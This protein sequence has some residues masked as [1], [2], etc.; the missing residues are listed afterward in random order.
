MS[1]RSPPCKVFVKWKCRV[2]P[3]KD[4]HDSVQG[5]FV[6]MSDITD[7]RQAQ[8]ELASSKRQLQMVGG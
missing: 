8:A 2:T 3:D 7:A 6:L 4:E 1:V 5:L